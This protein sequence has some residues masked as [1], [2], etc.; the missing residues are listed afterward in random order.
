MMPSKGDDYCNKK[1]PY[2]NAKL[3]HWHFLFLL[4]YNTYVFSFLSLSFSF[5]FPRSFHPRFCLSLSATN[6]IL[7]FI[8]LFSIFQW[9]FFFFTSA[10]IRCFYP[11][12]FEILIESFFLYSVK[13]LHL[14]TSQI[15]FIHSF[16]HSFYVFAIINF[17]IFFSIQLYFFFKICFQA[18]CFIIFVLSFKKL[19]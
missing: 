2:L 1:V 5:C 4:Y 16:V 19:F 11:L 17:F 13:L 8:S 7:L 12:E 15:L 9:L 18:Q 3:H 10:L 6:F 14:F